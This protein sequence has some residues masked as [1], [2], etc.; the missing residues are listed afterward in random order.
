MTTNQ[1]QVADAIERRSGKL[2]QYRWT[3]CAL[4]FAATVIN[5]IDRQM[6]GVLKPTLQREFGW[7]ELTYGDIVFWF[8]A[9]YA[10]GFIAFGRLMDRMG[11]RLG[12]TLA[13]TV[14]TLAH[15]AHG[16]ARSAASFMAARFVLGLGES[17]NFPASLKAVAD[18]FPKRERALAIGIFNAGANVGAILTPLIV[19]ALTVAFGW[20][21]AFLITG[22]FG[23]VWLPVWWAIYRLPEQHARVGAAELAHIRSDPQAPSAT[24]AWGQMFRVRETWAF[25]VGKFLIDPIWWMFLFWLPDFLV[26]RHGLNLQS[27]GPPLIAV[28]LMSNIG[29]VAGGWFSSR[30]MRQGVSL[31]MARKLTMLICAAC[32]LPIMFASAV[33]NL[34][35]AV[36]ILGLATAAHQGFSANLYALPSDVFPREAVGT[37]VGIGGAAGAI[38]GMAIAKYA[39]WVLDRLGSYTPIF[40]VAGTSYL[41]ALLVVHLLSPRLAPVTIRQA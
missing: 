7:S 32:V 13:M 14:W 33:D 12:Y 34:W 21:M 39:G 26:R 19:P 11:T 23:L 1:L 37:V 36:A 28:Y 5:Y 22:L 2:G 29:S 40:I 6:I 10:V 35:L 25:A 17:G 20:R 15:M 38:G 16:A 18:W 9:A 27:F 30:L 31:N 4:I 3:I 41:L 24:F 8:Q